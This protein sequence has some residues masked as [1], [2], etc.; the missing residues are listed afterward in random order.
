MLTVWYVMVLWLLDFCFTGVLQMSTS[1]LLVFGWGL[2][3]E[4]LVPV[5]AL[6]G[7][8]SMYGVMSHS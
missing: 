7:G 3:F 2:Y 4:R 5:I 6:V 1:E 8:I